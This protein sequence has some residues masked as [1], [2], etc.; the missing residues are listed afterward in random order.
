MLSTIYA[1]IVIL[2][3]YVIKK[4]LSNDFLIYLQQITNPLSI[5]FIILLALLKFLFKGNAEYHV[6][7]IFSDIVFLP[8]FIAISNF[9][10]RTNIKKCISNNIDFKKGNLFFSITHIPF[11]VLL[12]SYM[13]IHYIFMNENYPNAFKFFGA[14]HGTITAYFVFINLIVY[15]SFS[16]VFLTNN[17][18]YNRCNKYLYNIIFY[19]PI[20]VFFGMFPIIWANMQAGKALKNY[21]NYMLIFVFFSILLCFTSLFIIFFKKLNV[22]YGILPFLTLLLNFIFF[23]IVD[24][25]NLI[26]TKREFYGSFMWVLIFIL[27]VIGVNVTEEDTKKENE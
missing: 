21:E 9:L 12:S 19:N 16:L 27:F 4:F 18:S 6:V 11:I 1:V 22:K 15:I 17:E 10:I 25:A 24:D 14:L 26:A 7:V 5:F 13:N 2:G 8:I 20:H 23:I 3:I